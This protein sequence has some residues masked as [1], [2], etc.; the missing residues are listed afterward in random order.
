MILPFVYDKIEV[1][2]NHYSCKKDKKY[3]IFNKIEKTLHPTAYDSIFEQGEYLI[4][5][6]QNKYIVKNNFLEDVYELE[7]DQILV[8]N[9]Q[10]VGI[11][12]IISGACTTETP[13]RKAQKNS[14]FLATL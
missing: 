13:K 7:G 8:L 14:D 10:Y 3:Y 12:R 9:D 5:I 2:G 1:V 6:F 4:C 11:K